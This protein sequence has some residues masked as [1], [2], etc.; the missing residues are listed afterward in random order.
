MVSVP[1]NNNPIMPASPGDEEAQLL[2]SILYHYS[3]D[4]RLR[5]RYDGKH[6]AMKIYSYGRQICGDALKEYVWELMA[7]KRLLAGGILSVQT[8]DNYRRQDVFLSHTSEVENGTA[9]LLSRS[10]LHHQHIVDEYEAIR[11]R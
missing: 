7:D 1:M 4:L 6:D 5:V 10:A 8:P 11:A 9:F 2:E 3:G